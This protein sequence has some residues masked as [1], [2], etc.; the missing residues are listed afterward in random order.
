MLDP[1]DNGNLS[2]NESGIELE[3]NGEEMGAATEPRPVALSSR[4]E[5][6]KANSKETFV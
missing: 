1:E 4:K 3:E 6:K 2:G 5:M